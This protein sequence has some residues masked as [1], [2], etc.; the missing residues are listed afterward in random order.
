MKDVIDFLKHS[1][2]PIVCQQ[3]GEQVE[4]GFGGKYFGGPVCNEEKLQAEQDRANQRKKAA[5]IAAIKLPKMFLDCGL[6][7]YVATDDRQKRV[8]AR[9]Q[10]Y[11]KEFDVS[12]KNVI[13]SGATGSGK[14]HLAAALLKNLAARTQ[15]N[16]V[17]R[18]SVFLRCRYVSSADFAAEIRA[19]WDFKTRTKFEAEVINTYAYAD[20]LLI[21]DLGVN[22]SLKTDVWSAIFDMRYREKLP[23][24]ITTNL[25]KTELH[26]HIGDRAYDRVME[27]YVWANCVWQSYRKFSA[28]GEE[29]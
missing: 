28:D 6:K 8:V 29:L 1:T 27:R 18:E 10:Q 23:T 9:L 26:E 2:R 20:V 3:H 16:P 22:D 4:T 19:S 24:I 5:S 17:T 21:D 13:L 15:V 14:T 25:T 12:T 11:I 7:D